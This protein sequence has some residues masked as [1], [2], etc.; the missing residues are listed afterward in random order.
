METSLL[1]QRTSEVG[2][3]AAPT[4]SAASSGPPTMGILTRTVFR[5]PVT[6]LILPA[7]I[8]QSHKNDVI[9]VQERSIEIKE[10]VRG[11]L[12]H[13]TIKDD[14]GAIIRSAGVIKEPR[15][16]MTK[17]EPE[18]EADDESARDAILRQSSAMKQPTQDSLDTDD[19]PH[20]PEMPPQILVMALQSGPE[21]SLLFLCASHDE[22][23]AIRF[24]SH[25]IP[26][27]AKMAQS[28]RLGKHIAIDP[29]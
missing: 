25:Q 19:M 18:A 26:L 16:P 21:D 27:P 13:V 11:N 22:P 5:S 23:D 8:R 4:D 7:R 24:L 9:F 20:L 29:R 15:E 6:K 2:T 14:F 28:K 10:Y 17:V 1:P 12:E 3:R